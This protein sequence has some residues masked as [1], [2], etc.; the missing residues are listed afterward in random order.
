MLDTT[1]ER[2]TRLAPG[3]LLL[4]SRRGRPEQGVAHLN[5]LR[6]ISKMMRVVVEYGAPSEIRIMNGI[7]TPFTSR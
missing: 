2:A 5:K 7:C 3:V 4:A 6:R 1:A